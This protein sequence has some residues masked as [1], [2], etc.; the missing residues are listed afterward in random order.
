MPHKFA[1]ILML[2]PS[3]LW[4]FAANHR[5]RLF[6][7]TPILLTGAEPRMIPPG[8]LR[9]NV[10]LVTQPIDLRGMIGQILAMKPETQRMTPPPAAA[11]RRSAAA[12]DISARR[13]LATRSSLRSATPWPHASS[14]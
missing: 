14:R 3:I 10:T 8:F 5:G 12:L 4:R 7:E 13:I 2:H 1:H 11:K 6:P 9:K